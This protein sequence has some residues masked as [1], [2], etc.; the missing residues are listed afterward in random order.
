MSG[1]YSTAFGNYTA[2]VSDAALGN[3]TG[4]LLFDM[5]EHVSLLGP[6]I[7]GVITGLIWYYKEK[8]LSDPEVKRSVLILLTIAIAW[9][10]ILATMGVI[11]VKTL[12]Y[13]PGM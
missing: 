5:M 8:V 13:P 3:F 2:S 1:T 11:M 12:T 4:P 7:A 10:L 9:M 6:A